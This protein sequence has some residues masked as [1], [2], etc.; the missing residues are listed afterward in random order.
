GRPRGDRMTPESRERF[1]ILVER[2][3]AGL[4]SD[5][6]TAE[7]TALLESSEEA[8]ELYFRAV[9]FHL[10]LARAASPPAL[11]PRPIPLRQS[12]GAPARPRR[13]S[14]R[15]LIVGGGVP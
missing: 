8:R 15:V 9:E 1:A 6:E 14:G 11:A 3:L 7:L 13:S 10:D 5:A 12:T 4:L 2:R